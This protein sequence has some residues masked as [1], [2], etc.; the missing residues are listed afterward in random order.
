[1]S[2]TLGLLEVVSNLPGADMVRVL[3]RVKVRHGASG[4]G[5]GKVGVGTREQG[6][7]PLGGGHWQA[8][9]TGRDAGQLGAVA[10]RGAGCG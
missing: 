8:R 5:L 1:V 2:S 6:A 4:R 7:G 3:V 10:T 9:P